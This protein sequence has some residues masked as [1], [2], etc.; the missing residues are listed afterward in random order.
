MADALASGYVGNLSPAVGLNLRAT[1]R[2][3]AL[4]RTRPRA[5]LERPPAPVPRPAR[6]VLCQNRSSSS[7][8]LQPPLPPPLPL[9][10]QPLLEL[11]LQRPQ[12]PPWKVSAAA[13]TAAARGRA[14]T[15]RLCCV[16]RSCHGA[17]ASAYSSCESSINILGTAE[18]RVATAPLAGDPGGSNRTDPPS[19]PYPDGRAAANRVHLVHAFVEAAVRRAAA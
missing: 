19:R 8:P 5:S 9:P 16:T 13:E 6:H 2:I 7:Q 1:A 14:R 18:G 4:Q 3:P 12:R 10:P 15:L 17:T 11:L